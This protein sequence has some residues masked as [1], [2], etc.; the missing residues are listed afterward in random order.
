MDLFAA[1]YNNDVK[2]L[3]IFILQ[4][5]LSNYYWVWTDLQEINRV[6]SN[7]YY[8]WDLAEKPLK[9]VIPFSD[10]HL[11]KIVSEVYNIM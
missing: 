1:I 2:L 11:N 7:Y 10:S 6:N 9:Y 3:D 8:L 5:R 4:K